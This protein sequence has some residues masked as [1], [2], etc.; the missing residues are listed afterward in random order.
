MVDFCGRRERNQI[1]CTDISLTP[2]RDRG[3]AAMAEVINR[4]VSV[5]LTSEKL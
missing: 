1:P 5:S 2:T 3:D 4:I